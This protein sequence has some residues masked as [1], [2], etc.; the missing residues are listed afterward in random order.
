[1][2]F[3]NYEIGCDKLTDIQDLHTF[4]ELGISSSTLPYL[5]GKLRQDNITIENKEQSRFY[6]HELCMIQFLAAYNSIFVPIAENPKFKR[7]DGIISMINNWG[8]LE[9]YYV[10]E[11]KA[12]GFVNLDELC[13]PYNIQDRVGYKLSR[14]QK[15]FDAFKAPE[16]IRLVMFDLYNNSLTKEQILNSLKNIS[17]DRNK[18]ITNM[19]IRSVDFET[20][21]PNFQINIHL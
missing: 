1:M 3:Y 8:F 17:I 16:N 10:A 2:N 19:I 11:L 14:S 4:D 7:P 9:D 21:V 12:S 18:I 5:L 15:K 13:T 6:T 20:T